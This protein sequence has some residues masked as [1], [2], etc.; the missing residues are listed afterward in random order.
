MACWAP[1]LPLK[2]EKNRDKEE[3]KE[4]IG[5]EVGRADSFPGLTKNMLGPRKLGKTKIERINSNVFE[6]NSTRLKGVGIRSF[7]KC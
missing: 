5:D 4:R 6:F 7:Q 3:K 2:R 1:S